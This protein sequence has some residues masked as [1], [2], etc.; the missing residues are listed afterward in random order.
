MGLGAVVLTGCGQEGADA[1]APKKV[2]GQAVPAPGDSATSP[3]HKKSA[4]PSSSSK[5][6][7]GKGE[8]RKARPGASGNGGTDSS[9]TTGGSGSGSDG[10]TSGS[11]SCKTSDLAFSTSH[12]MA[13]GSL[14]VNIKNVGS[15]SCDLTGFP[16]ADLEGDAG[17]VI[18]ARNGEAPPPVHVAPGEETRFTLTYPPNDSGGSGATFNTLVVTPPNQTESRTLPVSI[19]MSVTESPS[20][21]GVRVGP[22]GAGK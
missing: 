21:P 18:A 12:G 1:A 2:A 6:G 22:V 19:N 10:G 11:S 8:D 4:S 9:G 17:P 13:E 15:S 14:L 3:S 20:S 7:G 5:S 16:G